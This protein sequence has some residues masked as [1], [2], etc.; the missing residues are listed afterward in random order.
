M[1]GRAD[2]QRKLLLRFV[3]GGHRAFHAWCSALCLLRRP[4]IQMEVA[5]ALLDVLA[6][7]GPEMLTVCLDFDERVMRMGY[8]SIEAV[9]LLRDA[10]IVVRSA[11]RMRTGLAIADDYGFVYTPTPLYLE[12]EPGP[13]AAPTVASRSMRRR[14]QLSVFQSAGSVRRA[15]T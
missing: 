10:G 4:G 11:P 3:V 15:G 5:H 12:S 13:D 8:G 6:R 2:E 9:K 1:S 14:T 7:L